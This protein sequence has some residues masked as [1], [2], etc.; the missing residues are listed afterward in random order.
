MKEN[1]FRRVLVRGGIWKKDGCGTVYVKDLTK[2]LW[3]QVK[4]YRKDDITFPTG[5]ENASSKAAFPTTIS[6]FIQTCY[7]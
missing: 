6:D 1:W 4:I 2:G 7:K 3:K 5:R